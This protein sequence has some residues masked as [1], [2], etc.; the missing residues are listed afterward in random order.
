MGGITK[1]RGGG[2]LTDKENFQTT[3]GGISPRVGEPILLE[4]REG[5]MIQ[6]GSFGG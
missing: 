4:K 1:M 3:C 5:R 6:A 2:P